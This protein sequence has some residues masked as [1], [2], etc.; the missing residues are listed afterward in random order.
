MR[1]AGLPVRPRGVPKGYTWS[2]L[3]KQALDWRQ[4]DTALA[5]AHGV[6]RQYIAQ[7]RAQAGQ[8]PSGSPAWRAGLG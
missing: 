2:K 8:P 4:R 7:L 1:L 5:K 6:S 3:K